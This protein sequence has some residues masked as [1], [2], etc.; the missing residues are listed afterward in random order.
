MNRYQI[1]DKESPVYTHGGKGMYTAEEWKTMH[2][3]TAIDGVNVVLAGGVIN[4]ALIENYADMVARYRQ[5]GAVLDTAKAPADVLIDIE[6]FEDAQA[7]AQLAAAQ[8]AANTPS[9]DE[10]IAAALELQ[11]MLALP[12]EGA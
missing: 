6:V 8:E 10:R 9:A 4:G 2:P 1:W 5:A 11:N 3:W 7:A 12:T